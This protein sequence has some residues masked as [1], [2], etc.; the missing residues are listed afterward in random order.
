MERAVAA[1]LQRKLRGDESN[2]ELRELVEEILED[3]LE[4]EPDNDD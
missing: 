1:D 3:Q 2:E 4:E